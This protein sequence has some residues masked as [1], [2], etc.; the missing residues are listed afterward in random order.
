MVQVIVD[1]VL[2]GDATRREITE[3]SVSITRALFEAKLVPIVKLAI[4]LPAWSAI[5]PEIED[6]VKSEEISPPETV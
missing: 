6:T 2:A 1:V 4:A 3:S 5:V